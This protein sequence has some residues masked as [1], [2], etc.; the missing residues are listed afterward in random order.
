MLWVLV[1]MARSL[2]ANCDGWAGEDSFGV[3][4][5]LT[6]LVPKENVLPPAFREKAGWVSGIG[7]TGRS[8]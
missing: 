1:V 7:G 2:E 4:G 6:A 5:G 3:E 8:G